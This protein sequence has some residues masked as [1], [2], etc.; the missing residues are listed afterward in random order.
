M[1]LYFSVYSPALEQGKFRK[2]DDDFVD[3]YFEL[4]IS[5]AE[6]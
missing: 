5:F 2:A 3:G 6:I 4:E 1:L